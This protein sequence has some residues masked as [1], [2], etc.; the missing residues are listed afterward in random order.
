MDFFL[1]VHHLNHLAISS[2]EEW[3]FFF[4]EY[5]CILTWFLNDLFRCKICQEQGKDMPEYYFPKTHSYY[6]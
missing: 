1:A 5:L 4:K 6:E 2:H 3:T